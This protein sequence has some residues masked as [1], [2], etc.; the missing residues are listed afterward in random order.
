MNLLNTVRSRVV[1]DEHIKVVKLHSSL[2]IFEHKNESKFLL[3][4]KKSVLD[5]KFSLLNCRSRVML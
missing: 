2:L 5:A 4:K 3:S 1:S